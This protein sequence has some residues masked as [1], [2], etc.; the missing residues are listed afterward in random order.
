MHNHVNLQVKWRDTALFKLCKCKNTA[1]S[2]INRV[3]VDKGE[4]RVP[5]TW[6]K[7]DRNEC[8]TELSIRDAGK[9]VRADCVFGWVQDAIYAGMRRCVDHALKTAL[10][11]RAGYRRT[12]PPACERKSPPLTGGKSRHTSDNWPR[13]RPTEKHCLIWG[14][15]GKRAVV[16][17]RCHGNKLDHEQREWTMNNIPNENGAQKVRWCLGVYI[18]AHRGEFTMDISWLTNSS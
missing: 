15:Y 8:V 10:T 5:K 2:R 7:V 9:G 3:S 18:F 16:T 4:Y 14:N 11:S 6:Y 13:R 12:A 1:L 17:Y